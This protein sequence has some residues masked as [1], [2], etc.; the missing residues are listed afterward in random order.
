VALEKLIRLQRDL[1]ALLN[2]FVSF[3]SFYRREGAAFQAG[4]LYLDAR[5]CDLTVE[6]SDTAA[7]AA[8][9]VNVVGGRELS[10]DFIGKF[11]RNQFFFAECAHGV[12]IAVAETAQNAER[13]VEFP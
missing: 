4:T 10:Y 11:L 2:N 12:H 3:S 8:H 1:L 6:V 5:S 7:H 13:V 9:G